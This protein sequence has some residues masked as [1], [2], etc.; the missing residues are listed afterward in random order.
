[1]KVQTDFSFSFIFSWSETQI[2]CLILCFHCT[3][4]VLD[5]TFKEP[6]PGP[7]L[8]FGINMYKLNQIVLR[9]GSGESFRRTGGPKFLV[10]TSTSFSSS[11]AFLVDPHVIFAA[12]P[13]ILLSA[14]REKHSSQHF[15]LKA[16]FRAILEIG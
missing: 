11:P 2:W 6:A 5:A 4:S 1:M 9:P 16:I 15:P 8:G 14:H 3:A 12:S 10:T 13:K 7:R